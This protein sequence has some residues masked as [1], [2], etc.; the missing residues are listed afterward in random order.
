MLKL[1][2]QFND[3]VISERYYKANI[4]DALK[5]PAYALINNSE[6]TPVHIFAR[7]KTLMENSEDVMAVFDSA[8][9]KSLAAFDKPEKVESYYNEVLKE[10]EKEKYDAAVA[11]KKGNSRDGQ[12]RGH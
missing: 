5:L 9:W 10:N 11:A 7:L 2:L 8:E 4:N 3:D 12:I 1:N 6:Q